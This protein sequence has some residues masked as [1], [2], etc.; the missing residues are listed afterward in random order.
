MT[1]TATPP[2]RQG[3]APAP[4]FDYSG[5]DLTRPMIDREGVEQWIPHRGNLLLLDALV[6]HDDA[7]QRAVGLKRFGDDEFWVAGHFPQRAIC[8]GVLLVEA[9]AQLSCCLYNIGLGKP[10]LPSFLRIGHASFRSAVEP[11]DEL[12]LLSQV[13]K[14]GKRRF[15][16]EIQGFVGERL[17]FDAGITGMSHGSLTP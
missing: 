7:C 17:A 16:C 13:I 8:P 9:G 3:G 14:G 5:V 15:V 12:I 1:E 6:W 10:T 4:L 11:G 2:E